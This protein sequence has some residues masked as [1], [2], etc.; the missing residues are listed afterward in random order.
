MRVAEERSGFVGNAA[1]L[2]ATCAAVLSNTAALRASLLVRLCVKNVIGI[3]LVT[4]LA[5]L[6]G[7]LFLIKRL[8]ASE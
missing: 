6:K 3:V 7:L 1:A 8:C 2:R 5:I 4:L